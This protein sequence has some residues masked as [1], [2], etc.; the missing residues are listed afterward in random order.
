MNVQ[1]GNRYKDK[2]YG[3]DFVLEDQ[4]VIESEPWVKIK[5]PKT[6]RTFTITEAQFLRDFEEADA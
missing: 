6:H 5:N 3:R 1:V 4:Q 2:E